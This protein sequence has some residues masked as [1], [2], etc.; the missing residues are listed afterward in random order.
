[1]LRPGPSGKS[2][3]GGSI[4]LRARVPRR[5]VSA[6]KTHLLALLLP[7]V[8]LG[9]PAALAQTTAFVGGVVWD[10]TG[11]PARDD[12]TLVVADGRIRSVSEAGDVPP[13]AE[14]VMLDG[15]F[16]MPGLINA[17]GHVSGRWA[18]DGVRDEDARIRGDLELY[19]RYG[20]TTV[21]S[22][23]DSEAVLRFKGSA[24]P[25]AAHARL[26]AAGP[27]VSARDPAGARARALANVEAGADFLK[28]RVDDNLGTVEK[29][30]WE[31]VQAV[32]DVG[33][34]RGVPVATHLFYLEDARRLLEMGSGLLAHSVR[35]TTV[36]EAFV[37]ELKT[38]GVCYVPTLVREVSTFVYE[39]RPGFFDEEFFTRFADSAEVARLSDPEFQR[40]VRESEAARRY[41]VALIQAMD[42]LKILADAG[43]RIA[44]GTDSGPA[45]RF[46]GFFEHMELGLMVGAGLTPQQALLAATRDA[47]RCLGL[48]DRGTLEPG[49]WADFLVLDANPLRM[50]TNTKTL[51]QVY[52]AGAPLLDAPDEGPGG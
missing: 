35:D 28:L 22:L 20:V 43:A 46:P 30:P 8:L 16:V 23:G 39:A 15:A 36:D 25:R 13:G 45:G 5:T 37:E 3:T 17:H 47:A 14:I 24:D 2:A 19:A 21:L 49:K 1:M 44:F 11:A 27:V 26:L 34:A 38:S 52:V 6:M 10:G 48:D 50:I 33:R 29:M 51:R 9:A 41:R 31:A 40:R 7:A 42:N 4:P 32:M 18:P 12:L